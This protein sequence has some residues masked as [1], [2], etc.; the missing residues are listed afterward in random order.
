MER[1]R[2]L[3]QA[4]ALR[5]PFDLIVVGAGINGAGIV[6]D[7]SLRGLSVLCLDKGAI[8]SGTTSASTR[9]I[10]G[11]LRY[12]EH[13]ELGLVRESLRER[14]TL[15]RIAP[16]LVHPMPFVV[17]IYEGGKRGKHL[18]RL[19]LTAYDLLAFDKSLPSHRMLSR[20][21]VRR[22]IPGLAEQGLIGAATYFDAQV[23]F[24][25]RLALENVIAG[26][27]HGAVVGSHCRVDRFTIE[28]NRIGGVVFT[29]V[30]SQE[31]NEAR[32]AITINAS[33]P[34]L[35]ELLSGEAGLRPPRMIGGT[36]GSH[37]VVA[38]FPGAPRQALYVEA[39]SNRRPYFA[40]PWNGL[41]LIGTTDIRYEG[42]L[43]RVVASEEEI[44]YLIDET[45]ALI[46]S[47]GLNG[48]SVLYTYAGV[49]PLPFEPK[50]QESAI[51]RRHIVKDHAPQIE[52]LISIIGGKLTTYRNLAEQAVDLAYRKMG[53]TPAP[54]VTAKVPLPGGST[55]DYPA[56]VE[57]FRGSSGLSEASSSH[58]LSVYGTRALDVLK[59]AEGQEALLAPF[60]EHG[61][62]GAEVPFSFEHEFA[63]TLTDMLMSC[64][65]AGWDADMAVGP[66]C[67]AADLAVRHAGWS[68]DEGRRQLDAYRKCLGRY[69]PRLLRGAS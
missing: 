47:A 6:R 50:G 63:V 22:Q 8:G 27:E 53:R 30:T 64:S 60:T 35:D 18:I 40:L 34:W 9:L 38:G 19:G 12:L 61:A 62:I 10:H 67:T 66:D 49:R 44:A 3:G 69:G 13:Y 57:G 68:K 42:D 43:D 46:P 15:L 28:G 41:Y 39:R 26:H 31:Q 33:G 20:D 1:N 25:E 45:N 5:Q 4:I 14:Q 16:H 24:P 52:G 65:M 21:E 2:Q 17:P 32:A 23:Q 56:F 37:I 7:A 55:P 59:R 51:T 48:E 29:D 54:C 58:L 11:G 36:K